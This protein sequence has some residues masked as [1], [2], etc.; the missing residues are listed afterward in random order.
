MF[1]VL[2]MRPRESARMKNIMAIGAVAICT[3]SNIYTAICLRA[4]GAAVIVCALAN[5]P[6]R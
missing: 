3:L 4:L 5:T 2:F 1:P 6:G